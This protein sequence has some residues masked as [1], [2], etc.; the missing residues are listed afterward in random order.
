MEKG[1][2]GSSPEKRLS[3]L[4]FAYHPNPVVLEF[5]G[6]VL[7]IDLDHIIPGYRHVLYRMQRT[8]HCRSLLLRRSDRRRPFRW[9]PTAASPTPENT[10][11]MVVGCRR[12][13]R[14]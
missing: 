7:R 6:I 13:A 8:F 4:S 9:R 1:I 14:G 12:C 3:G 10:G 5:D 2:T 11:D